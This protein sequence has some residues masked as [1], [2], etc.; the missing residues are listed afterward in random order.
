MARA[1]RPPGWG[2]ADGSTSSDDEVGNWYGNAKTEAVEVVKNLIYAYL[3]N[4]I[5]GLKLNKGLIF[6]KYLGKNEAKSEY[7]IVAL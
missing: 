1:S 5:S 6:R 4:L 2:V 3:L 7:L